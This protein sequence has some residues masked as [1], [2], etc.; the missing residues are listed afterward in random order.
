MTNVIKATMF[1]VALTKAQSAALA[2]CESAFAA[3]QLSTAAISSN[4]AVAAMAAPVQRRAEFTAIIKNAF[5]APERNLTQVA[6]ILSQESKD[7]KLT[8][9]KGAKGGLTAAVLDHE[10]LCNNWVK[11]G[12]TDK[13]RE[14]RAAHVGTNLTW[15]HAIIRECVTVPES[16][17]TLAV[18]ELAQ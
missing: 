4:K 14:N 2:H 3:G 18:S 17:P 9:V 13:S 5:S 7:A 12:S 1:A 10:L 16:A 11:A 6:R 15:I 8:C